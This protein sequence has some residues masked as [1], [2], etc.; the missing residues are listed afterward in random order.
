[1]PKGD[2]SSVTGY[3]AS[4]PTRVRRAL[5]RV[6]GI[7]RKAIPKADEVISYG[8]P[9]YKMN[10]R[11]VIYFAGWKQHYSLYPFTDRLLAAFKD[12]IARYEVSGKGTIR[13]PLSEPV[14]ARLIERIARFRAKEAA[15][16]AK[17]REAARKKRQPVT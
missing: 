14:P 2:I 10:G 9:S 11:Y 1:M 6:R 3:I 15:E 17:A 13:F 4:Q 8:I 12:D 16:Q 5:T 7:I